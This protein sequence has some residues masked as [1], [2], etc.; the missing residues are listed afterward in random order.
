M[1]GYQSNLVAE[2]IYNVYNVGK[3]LH[4]KIFNILLLNK[5]IT[6]K[7]SRVGKVKN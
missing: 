7:A 5:N 4:A 1:V 6:F 3:N 2:A